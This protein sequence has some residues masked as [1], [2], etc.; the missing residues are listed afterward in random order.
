MV[1]DSQA[2][3][4]PKTEIV[5]GT[6]LD[7]P[8]LL[9]LIISFALAAPVHFLILGI[10]GSVCLSLFDVAVLCCVLFVVRYAEPRRALFDREGM[11]LLPRGIGGLRAR[12]SHFRWDEVAEVRQTQFGTMRIR[13]SRPRKFWTVFSQQKNSIRVR[14]GIWTNPQFAEAIRSCVPAERIHAEL[15]S[16]ERLSFSV[17]YRWALAPALLLCAVVAA[18]FSFAAFRSSGFA[19]FLP[20][21]VLEL[22]ILA[23]A[24]ILCAD[25]APRAFRIIAGLLVTFVLLGSSTEVVAFLFPHGLKLVAGYWGALAGALVGAAMVAING[26]KSHRGPYAGATFLLAAAGFCCGWAGF[27][28][29]A[30]TRLGTGW[31]R[32]CSPW[33]P[34]GDAF[35][36][37]KGDYLGTFDQPTEVCWYSSDL[38]LESRTVLPDSANLL[39]IGQEAAVFG[40][41]HKQGSQLWF[42]PRDAEARVIDTA[43]AF[44]NEGRISPDSRHMLIAMRNVR[45]ETSGWKICDL[46]TGKVEP[47]NLPVPASEPAVIALRDDGSVLWLSGSPP[48]DNRNRPVSRFAPLPESGQFPHPGKP[49][50][51]W[52]WK[53]NS[54]DA[55]ARLY[56]AKTQWLEWSRPSKP[57]R[58]QVCRV[59]ENPPAR[60]EYV[61]L[62]FTQSPPAEAAIPEEEF[63]ANWTPPCSF[64]GRFALVWGTTGKFAPE[65]IVDVQAGRKFG[66]ESAAVTFRAGSIWWSPSA[67]KFLMQIPAVRLKGGRW[68]WPHSSEE[69]FEAAMAVYF[70]DMDRQ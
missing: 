40:V 19:G 54:A 51:V 61:A 42:L 1:S 46:E 31:L 55:P 13:L 50:V 22:T 29:I 33:T 69:M 45:N 17:R 24:M 53:I 58:L 49:Y 44:G 16:D 56:T 14:K 8:I 10:V 66:M 9:P 52:S 6:Q 60:I 35:L 57:G 20:R 2:T 62:D 41:A 68:R 37:T 34:S 18:A 32:S 11:T 28:Q 3:A 36:M 25:R 70:V 12:P 48:L 21:I 23:L 26:R 27:H 5:A 43:A 15:A 7:L 38:K 59:A 30:G 4:G 63:G 65:C 67:H 64:D 47:V 39:A